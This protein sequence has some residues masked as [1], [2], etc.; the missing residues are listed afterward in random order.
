MV[1]ED[2]TGLLDS[3][4]FVSLEYADDYFTS[5][6]VTSWSDKQP[7]EKEVLLINATDYINNIFDWKGK[8]ATPEQALNFPRTELYTKDGYEVEG[9]PKQL[10]EAVCE[11]VVVLLGNKQLY[12]SVNE[13]GAVTSEHIGQLSFTYD[14]SQKIKDSTLFESINNRLRGLYNDTSKKKIYSGKVLRKL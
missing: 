8:K 10:K 9:V 7:E 11:A 1:V 2:G 4:S 13:N 14:V 12:Q 5:H 3:N 6:G